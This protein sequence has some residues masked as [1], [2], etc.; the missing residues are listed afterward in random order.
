MA[1]IHSRTI[2]P[3]IEV[4]RLPNVPTGISPKRLN[5]HPPN[6]P[7]KIPTRRLMIRPEPL[8]FIIR[9]A[10]YPAT[11]PISKYHK[12]YIIFDLNEYIRIKIYPF[13]S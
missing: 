3:I 8:P 2:A 5:N 7:P 6:N 12:K 10:M 9:L 4:I 1:A 11:K 13:Y